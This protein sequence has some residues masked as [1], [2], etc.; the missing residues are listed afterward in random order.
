MYI[1]KVSF[2][3]SKDLSCCFVV[4]TGFN[5]CSLCVLHFLEQCISVDPG[6]G[7]GFL[8]RCMSGFGSGQSILEI[9][10]GFLSFIGMSEKLL[11]SYSEVIQIFF[12]SFQVLHLN[13]SIDCSVIV[14]FSSCRFL[15]HKL[16]MVSRPLGTFIFF[17]T[18][19]GIG[20][21]FGSC[22]SG[23][24]LSSFLSSEFLS[25]SG[26]FGGLGCSGSSDSGVIFATGA[27]TFFDVFV[28]ILSRE[29]GQLVAAVIALLA[30]TGRRDL[31]GLITPV[32]SLPYLL[33]DSSLVVISSLIDEPLCSFV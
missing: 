17:G 27:D 33:I 22:N 10:T 2:S 8:G 13:F 18:A 32:S 23:S 9:L 11:V 24:G 25:S 19:L 7:V 15:T 31:V 21:G 1:L 28:S 6:V 16:M 12:L 14:F 30:S 26:F 5:D 4:S 29:N 3:R 20:F